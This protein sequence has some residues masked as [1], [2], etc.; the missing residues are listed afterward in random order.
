MARDY[1]D[2]K[3]SAIIELMRTDTDIKDLE[4]EANQ[5][6]LIGLK[7]SLAIQIKDGGEGDMAIL[8][9]IITMDGMGDI[10]CPHLED[11]QIEI[12]GI[13]ETEKLLGE[14]REDFGKME[15][16]YLRM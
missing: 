3:G 5:L 9:M 10:L 13:M 15:S 4:K 6:K 11:G 7:I 14:K 16:G 1:H 8:M 12:F 2:T